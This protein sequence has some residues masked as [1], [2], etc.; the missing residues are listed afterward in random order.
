[1]PAPGTGNSPL[2]MENILR[3][4]PWPMMT[5]NRLTAVA[6]RLALA[7]AGPLILLLLIEAGL[8][9]ATTG[10]LY[11]TEMNPHYVAPDGHV[12]LKPSTD[13]FWYGC[14]Y[15]INSDG[16]RMAREV[17]TDRPT[18][19][20]GLGD[21]ITLGM[22]VPYTDDVWPNRLARLIEERSPGQAEVINTGVQ[23]WNLLKRDGGGELVPADFTA[24]IE[25]LG[26][27]I[28]FRHVVYCV[29][30]NDVPSAA[31]ELFAI[32]NAANKKRFR[33]FPESA[34]EWFKRKAFYRLLRDGYRERR[35]YQLDFSSIPTP[36]LS[37]DFWNNV[38]VEVRRLRA[39]CSA[40]EAQLSC[41]IVPYS[42]EVLPQNNRL[43][44]AHT[45]WQNIFDREGI[46]WRDITD[47]VNATNVLDYFVLGDYIHLNA[48]GHDLV[49]QAALDL[50]EESPNLGVGPTNASSAGP[51][52]PTTP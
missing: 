20:V 13:T 29:C 36:P 23:G 8:R 30:M 16:F 21:S 25:A 18:V 28:R 7:V 52:V 42:F 24:C 44:E 27:R 11:F 3:H 37:E 10:H 35:F 33:L 14:R 17:R 43:L 9:L 19:I 6:G 4:D 39:A 22:G 1:M 50:L 26:Q 15:Q 47:R 49:A 12:R 45:Q 40:V 34:R 2:A 48:R 32:D 46:P 31:D 41:V 38:A 5:R 51:A